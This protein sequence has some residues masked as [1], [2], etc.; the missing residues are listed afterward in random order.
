MCGERIMAKI[1]ITLKDPDGVWDNVTSYGYD[2]NEL[3]DDVDS[4][5]SKF[6]EWKEYV[7]IELDTE[8][9][10]ARVVPV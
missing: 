2:M 7:T 9:G 10:E 6:V 3:P 8:T 1:Q 4:V 5:F